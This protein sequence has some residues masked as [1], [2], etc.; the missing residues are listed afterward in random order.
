MHGMTPKTHAPRAQW[1]RWFSPDSR[2]RNSTP[3]RDERTKRVQGEYGGPEF[4]ALKMV[5]QPLIAIP[6]FWDRHVLAGRE[7]AF[8]AH[9]INWSRNAPASPDGLPVAIHMRFLY[10]AKT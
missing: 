3:R 9:V 4:E 5:Q 2:S 6:D 10:L 1:F 8:K 7:L